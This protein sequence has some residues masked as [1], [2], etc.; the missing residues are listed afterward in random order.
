[1]EQLKDI[2]EI[3]HPD[4]RSTAWVKL[5]RKQGTSERI[6]LDDYYFVVEYAQLHDGVPEDGEQ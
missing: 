5:D 4:F 3:A 6:T 2:S 1:M